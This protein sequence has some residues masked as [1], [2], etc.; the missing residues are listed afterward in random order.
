MLGKFSPTG[1]Q[2][3][4]LLPGCQQE[5]AAAFAFL[6][7]PCLTAA[8]TVSVRSLAWAGRDKLSPD[9]FV[10]NRLA[11]T[12][13]LNCLQRSCWSCLE[14]ARKGK[15]SHAQLRWHISGPEGMVIK[16][17]LLWWYGWSQNTTSA[18]N[19]CFPA[20]GWTL[21]HFMWQRDRPW[22]FKL[23]CAGLFFVFTSCVWKR[24]TPK[25]K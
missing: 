10:W 1:S 21:W 15:G 6:A 7:V 24:N 16:G 2:R 13:Y 4:T 3:C 14:W 5:E 18:H 17:I 19:L 22:H 9:L 25:N 23:L 11:Q 8:V 12:S 20:A